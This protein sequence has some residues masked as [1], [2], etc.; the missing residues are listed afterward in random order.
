[1]IIKFCFDG[2]YTR[3]KRWHVRW[4]R[5]PSWREFVTARDAR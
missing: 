4:E 1:M 5:F 3:K 2:F